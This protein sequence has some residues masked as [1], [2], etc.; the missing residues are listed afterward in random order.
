[1]NK[2]KDFDNYLKEFPTKDGYF[3]E[4]GGSYQAKELIEA[5][6]E[7]VNVSTD[8]QNDWKKFVA[9][10]KEKEIDEIVAKLDDLN[11]KWEAAMENLEA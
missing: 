6:I 3:G 2:Y 7:T 5:F 9:E 4:Y 11:I 8:V 1:M 10:Q